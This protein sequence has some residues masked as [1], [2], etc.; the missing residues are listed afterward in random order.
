MAF[1]I[2]DFIYSLEYLPIKAVFKYERHMSSV[3]PYDLV[4]TKKYIIM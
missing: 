4:P 3:T 1:I 2:N